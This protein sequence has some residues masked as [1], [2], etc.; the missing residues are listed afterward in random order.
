MTID[1]AQQ[2][3]AYNA[4]NG[5]VTEPV[6]GSYIQALAIYLGI[7]APVNGSWLQAICYYHNIFL[8]VGGSWVQALCNFYGEY[9]AINDSWWW[10][11]AIDNTSPSTPFTW[12]LDTVLWEN[13][14]RTWN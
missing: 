4:S 10:T 5:V 12:D 7:T 9:V 13:E 8:P 3:Y 11:L 6:N 2:M 1:D 14:S